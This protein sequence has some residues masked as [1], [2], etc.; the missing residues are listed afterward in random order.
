MRKNEEITLRVTD[1]N[2]RGYGVGHLESAGSPDDG[3]TVF[4]GGAVTGD[5]VRAKVIKVAKEYLVARVEE[6]LSPSPYRVENTC[7]AAGC[8]GCVSRGITYAHERERKRDY[9]KAAFRKAGLPEAEVEEVRSTGKISRYRNK[10]EYP[11]CV[12]KNGNVQA[13]F[14]ATATHRVVPI[15]DCDLQP[16]AFGQI[17]R[18]LCDFCNAHGVSIYDEKTGKGLLRHFY[19]R[20]AQSGGIMVCLVVNGKKL[21]GEET[22]FGELQKRFPQVVSLYLNENNE[23]TNVILGKNYRLLGGEP[24]LTDTLCGLRFQ[25]APGAFYQVNH[26]ACELLYGIAKEKAG[27]TGR[28]LLLDL[29]CGIGTIGLSMSREAKEVLGIE[30]VKEAVDCANENAKRNGVDN[31]KFEVGDAGDPKNLLGWIAER[32]T[33]PKDTVVV[34]DPPR[35]GT[36]PALIRALAEAKIGKVVYVSCNPDTLARDCAIFKEQGY[37]IGTV[38]PVDLFPRTGHVETVILLSRKS[39]DDFLESI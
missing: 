21:P 19:L 37:I 24:Y 28:E 1:L 17:V 30:V 7:P 22:L 4:V 36:T 2:N 12:D 35:K 25:I 33:D 3:I 39:I 18:S 9:V 20:T 29:Y 11:V 26:D 6:I 5:L 8:G 27:L 10:A 23:N 31:A 13:G 34:I 14:Y 38:T 15:A 32:Q 16:E